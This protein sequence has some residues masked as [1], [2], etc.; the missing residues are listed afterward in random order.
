MRLLQGYRL[1]A[2]QHC[3]AAAVE[4]AVQQVPPQAR[5][6]DLAGPHAAK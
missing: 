5:C 4:E 6:A 2:R 3:E 1:G